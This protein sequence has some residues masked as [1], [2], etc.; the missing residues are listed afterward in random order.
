[1]RN[2]LRT[3][4]IDLDLIYS[5]HLARSKPPPKGKS[6]GNARHKDKEHREREPNQEATQSRSSVSRD[7]R[8][9]HD[10]ESSVP[11]ASENTLDKSGDRGLQSMPEAPALE[12]CLSLSNDRRDFLLT[13]TDSKNSS[14]S[15]RGFCKL[16]LKRLQRLEDDIFCLAN[17]NNNIADG[18]GD[19]EKK[20]GI[21]KENNEEDIEEEDEEDIEEED[22]EEDEEDDEEDDGEEDEANRK[23]MPGIAEVMSKGSGRLQ[24]A[25]ATNSEH[26]ASEA[27][28]NVDKKEADRRES[29]KPSR[30]KR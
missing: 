21:R 13:Q 28:K 4:I 18:L 10:T 3:A 14:C 16:V 22:E 7:T 6:S 15:D 29:G 30:T 12:L 17:T 1:M 27:D 20:L 2:E 24:T 23:G 5:F 25:S 26:R 19:V 11:E 9:E 8:K